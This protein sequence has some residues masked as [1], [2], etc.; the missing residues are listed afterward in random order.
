MGNEPADSASA[1]LPIRRRETFSF[2]HTYES[3]GRYWRGLEKAGLIRPTNGIRLVNSPWGNDIYR[4]NTVA[5][6]GGDLEKILQQRKC[7]FIVDR[8]VGGSQYCPYPFDLSLVDH[9]QAMLGDK[10]LGGQVH[11]T[12]CNTHNDWGRFV[13]ANQK[14]ATE[15][16]NPDELRKYFTD[17]DA[18]HW[19]E[20][21]TLDDY[22]GHVHFNSPETLWKEIERLGKKQAARFHGRF[23]YCEGSQHGR[24]A[25]HIFYK[26][27]ANY[28]IAEVGPWA[29]NQTQLAI[30]SLRGAAK[31]AGKPWGVFFAPW[32]PQGCTCFIPPKEISW[33]VPEKM[34][35]DSGWPIGPQ[36]GCSSAMQRRIF[37]HTYLAGAHTL[38]EE[39]GAEDNLLNWDEGTLSSYGKVTRDF[40]DFQD[41][42]PDVGEPFTPVALVRDASLPPPDESAWRDVLDKLFRG[43]EADKI[44]A[45]Q[46]NSGGAEMACYPPC[47]LPEVFDIVPSD[48]PAEVWKDYRDIIP[49]GVSSLPSGVQACSPGEVY[50]RLA[51]AVQKHSPFARSTHLPMQINHRRSD[52]AWIVALYNPWGA[53]RGDVEQTGS[54]LNEAC[55]IHDILKPKFAVAS[56]KTLHAWPASS[57]ATLQGEDIQVT[58]G[59]G[60]VLILEI[61]EK[62]TL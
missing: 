59:P 26:F 4:F 25:W 51:G 46:E 38:H 28:C 50:D 62:V 5:K 37:F 52:G 36:Y 41:A 30:L 11:E 47:A 12:V 43:A 24:F 31:A 29:S 42:H 1:S 40:L 60:G 6:I 34:L 58:V 22:A 35:I 19:L 57:K 10:L 18:E 39:W 8:V 3:T 48:A 23:S 45:L 2:L 32:G 21:G 13:K 33:H 9:Y 53:V 20:Y 17:Q 44:A 16:I 14:F 7:H 49:V 15:P 27:G 56:M 55:A 54:I 61:S